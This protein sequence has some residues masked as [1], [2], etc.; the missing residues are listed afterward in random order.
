MSSCSFMWL[1]WELP[2]RTESRLELKK[3]KKDTVGFFNNGRS[4]KGA[5]GFKCFWERAKAKI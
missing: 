4:T 2:S 1:S 5:S 3:K